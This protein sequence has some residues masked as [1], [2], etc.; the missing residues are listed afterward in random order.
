MSTAEFLQVIQTV[1][2]DRRKESHRWEK[3]VFDREIGAKEAKA[4]H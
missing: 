3:T 4:R 2:L 1:R